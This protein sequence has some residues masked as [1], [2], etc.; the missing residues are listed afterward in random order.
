MGTLQNESE[1]VMGVSSVGST[2]SERFG[3]GSDPGEDNTHETV[4][5]R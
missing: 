1:I 2:E 3:E 5:H 4:A